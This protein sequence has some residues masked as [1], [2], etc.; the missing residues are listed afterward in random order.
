MM[1]ELFLLS[2]RGKEEEMRQQAEE[3]LRLKEEMNDI[4]EKQI[5]ASENDTGSLVEDYK[6]VL[7]DIKSLVR[8]YVASGDR[9]YLSLLCSSLGVQQRG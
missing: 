7:L 3:L 6:A 1:K 8:E 5:E 9:E 4:L 2:V